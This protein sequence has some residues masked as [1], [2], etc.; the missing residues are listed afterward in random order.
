MASIPEYKLFGTNMKGFNSTGEGETRNYLQMLRG[1][2]EN[3][4]EPFLRKAYSIICRSDL[5]NREKYDIVF[6]PLSVP[7]EAE[8]AAT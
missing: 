5:G 8:Q 2:Q 3:V 1:M 7:T 6:N 4:L